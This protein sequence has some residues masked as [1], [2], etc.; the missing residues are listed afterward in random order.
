[1]L[2]ISFWVLMLIAGVLALR[3][4]H[5]QKRIGGKWLLRAAGGLGV[6]VALFALTYLGG[7]FYAH[8][9]NRD[10]RTIDACLDG[11]GRWD[12]DSRTCIG[13]RAD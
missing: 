6:I 3:W 5:V 1:M 9:F 8:E 10:F 12:N 13:A 4:S 7:L 11:G 2:E